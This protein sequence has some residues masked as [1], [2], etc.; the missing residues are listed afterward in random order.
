MEHKM[1]DLYE[2][3]T[4]CKV[5]RRNETLYDMFIDDFKIVGKVDGIVEDKGI[6]VEHKRRIRGLL[7]KIPYHELVQCYMYMK[8]TNLQTAHL[9]ES[10]G[11]H[12][13]IHDIEFNEHIWNHMCKHFISSNFI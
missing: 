9:V 1:L 6:V 12:I 8:M 7:H 3:Q 13:N 11:N 4:N 5:S 2:Q 10:F